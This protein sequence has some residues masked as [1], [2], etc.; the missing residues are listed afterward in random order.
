M[1]RVTY[2]RLGPDANGESHFERRELGLTATAFAPPA[3]PME[4]SPVAA[5]TGWRFLHLP[6]NWVGGWHPTPRR[7]W[8]F[9]LRGELDFTASDGEV[10]RIRPGSTM[11]LED[12]TGRGHDSRVVGDGDALLVAVQLDP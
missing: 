8:I 2:V 1:D 7:I 11:L 6:P 10:H 4:V 12:T 5:A 3:P 9:C